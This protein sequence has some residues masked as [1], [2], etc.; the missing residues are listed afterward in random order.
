MRMAFVNPGDQSDGFFALMVAFMRQA[1]HGLGVELEIIDCHRDPSVLRREARALVSGPKP[2]E[3]LLLANEQGLAIDILPQADARGTKV[4]LINEGLMMADRQ[5]LGR[6]RERFQNWLGELVPD[7]RQAGYL[8]G[9]SLLQAARVKRRLAPDQTIH[10]FG[11]A[12][13]FTMSSLLRINGLRDAVGEAGDATLSEVPP[14]N[15]D[16]QMAEELTA[17]LLARHPQTTV[18]WSASDTMALGAVRAVE[19]AGKLPGRDILIGGIDWSRAAFEAIRRGTLCASV[20][21]HFLDGAWG[22]LLLHDY[23][24]GRDFG[25]DQITSAF[26]VATSENVYNFEPLVLGRRAQQID[27]SSLARV[28]NPTRAGYDFSV[29]AALR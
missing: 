19:A 21:G 3:Y 26:S 25:A 12:G 13:A 7:D 6:P 20:G 1:A 8:L 5:K 16:R 22:I 24:N 2:P 14:A 23:H 27:F 4:L 15:W 17:E 28:G 29:A 9:R 18:I 10:V 11:L